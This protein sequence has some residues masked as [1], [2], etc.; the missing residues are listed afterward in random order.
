[1]AKP[2]AEVLLTENEAD[3]L[4]NTGLMP[5]ASL[6]GQD[7]VLLVRLQSISELPAALAG[8]WN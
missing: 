7:A 4:L 5:L 8:R 6:K 3:F 2:C 1:M